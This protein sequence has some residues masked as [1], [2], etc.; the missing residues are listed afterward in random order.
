MANQSMS[1]QPSPI[2]PLVSCAGEHVEP[3]VLDAVNAVVK[4]PLEIPNSLRRS[5]V[6]YRLTG[7]RNRM[8][9]RERERE[10]SEKKQTKIGVESRI[11]IDRVA[12]S[13]SGR[14][15]P[16]GAGSGRALRV[17]GRLSR[18]AGAGRGSP[19]KLDAQ[20][21]VNLTRLMPRAAFRPFDSPLIIPRSRA[22]SNGYSLS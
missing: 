19:D 21:A 13:S 16:G 6:W 3:S 2:E 12:A 9:K 22:V 20:P 1:F 10:S 15:G 4:E 8:R 7:D 17:A 14:R 11:K 5:V 18:G